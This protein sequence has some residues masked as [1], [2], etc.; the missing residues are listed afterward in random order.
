MH[1]VFSRADTTQR[2]GLK[3]AQG[4]KVLGW[5]LLPS[6]DQAASLLQSPLPYNGSG[7]STSRKVFP[8]CPLPTLPAAF[9]SAPRLLL[10]E[11]VWPCGTVRR[12][13]DVVQGRPPTQQRVNGALGLIQATTYQWSTGFSAGA[14]DY[15]SSITALPLAACPHSRSFCRCVL[16][17][18]VHF[19]RD[20]AGKQRDDLLLAIRG[21]EQSRS[22]AVDLRTQRPQ[23]RS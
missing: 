11:T 9:Q 3:D 19:G 16:R 18:E 4:S 14:E 17:S 7:S 10:P 5:F 6:L 2:I 20:D 15:Y 12:R 13:V 8:S 1:K 21:V 23:A 22:K